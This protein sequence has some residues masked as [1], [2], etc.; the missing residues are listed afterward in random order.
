[1]A[2]DL[3]FCLVQMAKEYLRS[4]KESKKSKGRRQPLS[5][6]PRH[7]PLVVKD[8]I[9]D[10]GK[11]CAHHVQGV[12]MGCL[13][14]T[15][16]RGGLLRPMENFPRGTWKCGMYPTV[17]QPGGL[18]QVLASF[19]CSSPVQWNW[20]TCTF[21]SGGA[22]GRRV[23]VCVCDYINLGGW[24]PLPSSKT[25]KASGRIFITKISLEQFQ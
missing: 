21:L 6:L 22:G 4:M 19:S 12:A 14:K 1:M 13:A 11:F 2:A 25:L 9:S 20:F 18:A 3:A 10:D 15:L 8:C 16:D 5:K 24:K 17:R 7:H 23:C